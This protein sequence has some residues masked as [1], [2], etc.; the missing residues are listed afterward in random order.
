MKYGYSL[1]TVDGCVTM[2]PPTFRNE[3]SVVM[4]NSSNAQHN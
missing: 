3:S 1:Q 4:G 2:T